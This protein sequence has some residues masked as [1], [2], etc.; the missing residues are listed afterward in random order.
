MDDE[1][2]RL[3]VEHLATAP[4][5]V[6]DA[7]G[8]V[9]AACQGADELEN[10]LGG[11]ASGAAPIRPTP[12]PSNGLGV[13]LLAL[14]VAGFRGVGR[15][16]V[17][18]FEPRPGLTLVV[19]RNGSGKS[20]FSEA[21][22]F[23][24]TGAN[25]RWAERSRVWSQGWRNLHQPQASIVAR[26]A[27]DG[28]GQPVV[29]GAAWPDEGE[30]V[31]ARREMFSP[32]KG[33]IAGLGW[34]EALGNYRPF[35]SYT[36][37]GSLLDEGPT[38]LY[39]AVASILGLQELT[40]AQKLIAD[41]RI[42]RTNMQKAVAEQLPA[43]LDR[44]GAINDKRASASF[45]AL[46]S[47]RWDLDVVDRALS[48]AIEE[49]DPEA[50][51]LTLRVL[52]TVAGPDGARVE[53]I[54]QRLRD[55][56][57][58]LAK[59]AETDSGRAK[60]SAKLLKDALTYHK[61]VGDGECPVCR[62]PGALD[63]I[64][65]KAAEAEVQ[66]LSMAAAQADQAEAVAKAT[67]SE[68]RGL[69]AAAPQALQWASQVGVDAREAQ[70]AWA[71]F[72]KAPAEDELT[73]V[74]DHLEKQLPALNAAL[75]RLR[76]AA[77]QELERR[78][79]AW[80]PIAHDLTDW[81]T[82]ARAA[83]GQQATIPALKA[84]EKW[85]KGAVAALRDER[86]T[87]IAEGVDRNWRLL[88]QESNVK[89]NRPKLEGTG[90][91][92]RVALDIDVDGQPGAALAVMSQGELN[93]LALSL[94]LPRAT[95]PE[96]PFRFVVID[97]PVQSMDPAKIEGLA[98]VLEGTAMTRQVVVFT[99]DDR[100]PQ[101]IWRLDI[102]ATILEVTRREHS[103]VEVRQIRDVV[104]RYL[105]DAWAVASE[106]NLPVQAARV[107][108]GFC[109]SALEESCAQVI[110]RRRLAAGKRHDEVEKEIEGLSTV[111]MWMALVLFD[112]IERGGEV[113]KRLN[114]R[115]GPAAGNTFAR[116]KKGA[117]EPDSGD[118]KL[119]VNYTEK[120][121]QFVAEQR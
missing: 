4:P 33:P 65:R 10:A 44:L 88:R 82:H 95:L 103:V 43:L 6:T 3:V 42:H 90:N 86:F 73:A 80:R 14:E 39:D 105:D 83:E 110:W 8:L 81:L 30:L 35:L 45:K 59:A 2:L 25:Y 115:L 13:W 19:G 62:R 47:R 53:D 16:T 72:L 26:F 109:R 106:A 84:A 17:V 34:T 5:D 41:A 9:L 40:T 58:G 55:A 87:P 113:M 117:H 69:M 27:K 91:A 1:L 32:T 79:N 68:A 57:D 51:L 23:L 107:V 96:S 52:S 120:L 7:Q 98:R 66:V 100:L 121:T 50:E 15:R 29:V 76:E 99:H 36:E 46:S 94:F 97:D 108:P 116:L 92:R 48:G 67:F 93:C 20:S 101:A 71:G 56:A 104:H 78:E 31:D 18:N 77:S 114:E 54:A 64:W 118:L 102:P 28:A 61:H 60:R 112:E 37:L 63:A 24:L 11:T 75:L 111:T 38:K 74:A 89:L 22:E 49:G 21:L 119:L 12:V 85:M 70:V